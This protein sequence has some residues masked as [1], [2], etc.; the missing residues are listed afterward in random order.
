[1]RI[2]RKF[3]LVEEGQRT[4]LQPGDTLLVGDKVVARYEL[5]SAENRSFV[6]VDAFREACFLPEDQLSGPARGSF[7]PIRV[8]GL[9]TRF[10][11]CYR[12]IRADRTCWWLDVCPEESSTWEETFFVTQAGTFT[13]PVMTVESLYAPQYRANAA[14]RAP[15]STVYP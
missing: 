11:Q 3:Y 9:W 8:D 4:E 2:D 12:D 13:T 5:W 14:Y 6:R 10:P 7:G 15:L 1:M